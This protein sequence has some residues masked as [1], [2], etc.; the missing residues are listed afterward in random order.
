MGDPIED[1][2]IEI[3]IKDDKTE[4]VEIILGLP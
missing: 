2:Y 4:F 3:E 1:L